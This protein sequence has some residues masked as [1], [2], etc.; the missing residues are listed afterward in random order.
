MPRRKSPHPLAA[1][2]GR[3]IRQLREEAGLTI[4]KLAFESEVR[5]KGH[6]SSIE[7]G[8]VMPTV[9]TL[10]SLAERLGVL[11]A[12]LVINPDAD[13]RQKL[14]DLSRSL[15]SGTVRKL[16]REIK[17]SPRTKLRKR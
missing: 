6:L 11:V 16:N 3:R 5:S 15:P 4:E 7:K 8:L 10:S 2:V 9:A 12:D 14:I 1:A 17:H 13:D